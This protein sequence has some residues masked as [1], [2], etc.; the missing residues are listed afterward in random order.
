MKFVPYAAAFPALALEWE[1]RMWGDL[2]GGMGGGDPDVFARGRRGGH[3]ERIQDRIE[4]DRGEGAGAGGRIRRPGPLHRDDHEG[5]G[6]I[7]PRRRSGGEEPPLRGAGARDGGGP[8]RDGA[9]RRDDPVR[10]HLLHL[11]GLHAAFHPPGGADG[12]PRRLRV[13]ARLRRPGGGRP[14][15]PA[16][17]AP[18]VAPGD[19]QPPRRPA[20]GR[21]R[22]GGGVARRPRADA[23]AD[24]DRPHASE[25]PHPAAGGGATASTASPAAPTSFRTPG[26]GGP[27]CSSWRRV[28]RCTWRSP[29]RSSF[30]RRGF[31]PGW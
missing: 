19:A 14:H 17:G 6:G 30:R 28:R 24:G 31:R 25:D 27:T 12:V 7:P 23:G 22:D 26:R 4:R 1:R 16:G 8:Q 21:Q 3:P 2:P 10:R 18:G 9:A 5:R 29:R 11:H 13:D 20:R 15:A